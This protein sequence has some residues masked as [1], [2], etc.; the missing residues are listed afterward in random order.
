MK[1]ILFIYN[2]KSGKGK[3]GRYAVDISSFFEDKGCEV[4]TYC[5]KAALDGQSAAYQ[6]A[7]KYDLI[8]CAG[9]ARMLWRVSGNL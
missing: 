1:K 3:T 6:N 4:D 8:V 7:G 5:T 2:P 9:T